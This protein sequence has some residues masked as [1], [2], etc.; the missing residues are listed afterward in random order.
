MWDP[1]T[2]WDKQGHLFPWVGETHIWLRPVHRQRCRS[3]KASLPSLVLGYRLIGGISPPLFF[4]KSYCVSALASS[5]CPL[6]V[7]KFRFPVTGQTVREIQAGLWG[8]GEGS[9]W[10]W[11]SRLV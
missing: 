4:R 10:F 8:W 11:G 5:G 7:P 6:S 9:P 3:A 2:P 1:R